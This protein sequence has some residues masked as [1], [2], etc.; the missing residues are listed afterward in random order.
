MAKATRVRRKKSELEKLDKYYSDRES[1]QKDVAEVVASVLSEDSHANT[2]L[3]STPSEAS[4]FASINAILHK[5]RRTFR[6]K[7][8]AAKRN[9][10]LHWQINAAGLAHNHVVALHR[11]FYSLFKKHIKVIRKI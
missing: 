1:K 8:Y 10:K 4:L 2:L 5:V 3:S 11:R 9:K 7:L 6:Y